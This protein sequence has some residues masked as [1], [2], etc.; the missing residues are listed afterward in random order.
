MVVPV[1]VVSVGC[2]CG[3]A[4]GGNTRT[5]AWVT[6]DANGVGQAVV[7]DLEGGDPRVER[8]PR[9]WV[10]AGRG[11]PQTDQVIGEGTHRDFVG[12]VGLRETA[13]DKVV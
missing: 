3:G 4:C 13:I 6:V 12:L 8:V 2:A 11:P 10:V 5:L 1:A 7:V 9:G